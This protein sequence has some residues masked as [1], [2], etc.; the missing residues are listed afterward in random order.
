MPWSLRQVVIYFQKKLL[1]CR[2]FHQACM[3]DLNMTEDTFAY[4]LFQD[5]PD[6]IFTVDP[7]GKFL[8]ANKASLDIAECSY[9]ELLQLSFIPFIV[10]EELEVVMSHFR[11]ALK[12]EISNFDATIIS[13]K[14][15]VKYLNLTRIPMV[16]NE[17]VVGVYLI[18][19]DMTAVVTA[20]KQHEQRLKENELR[21]QTSIE[22]FDIVSKATSD[23]IWDYDV[24]TGMVV[25][26]RAI[27]G[28]FGY[29][30]T[31]FDHDWGRERVHPEDFKQM[32]RKMRDAVQR[33][34]S[35]LKTEYRFRCADGSYKNVMDRSF[36]MYDESGELVRI[37][38]SM[39][40]VTARH[41]YLQT[42]EAQNQQLQEIGWTQSHIVRAPL[43]NILG[44]AELL[45]AEKEDPESRRELLA[46]LLKSS[47]DLDDIIKEIIR[48]T[49][50]IH[51]F[52]AK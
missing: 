11:S 52:K 21:T 32:S 33:R 18:A 28:L 13:V 4:P 9:E 10:P 43:A 7:E 2:C 34:K 3:L 25:W 31:L 14:G 16:S 38:G 46:L 23:A 39:E 1:G 45:A 41:L 29:K 35:R 26:N 12:G 19:R 49:E 50:L 42:V 30:E 37:I 48:K 15:N 24:A 44:I 17:K 8:T 27:K 36:L 51:N 5:Y 6:A 22:R 40:D 47:A 20:R